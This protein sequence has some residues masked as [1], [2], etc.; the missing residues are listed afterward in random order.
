[1]KRGFGFLPIAA[2]S[3]L[4]DFASGYSVRFQ[5]ANPIIVAV[6]MRHV[7]AALTISI[8]ETTVNNI[9]KP[10]DIEKPKRA[11]EKYRRTFAKYDSF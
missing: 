6:A 10:T 2:K 11:P 4:E 1:M 8:D 3:S 7:I 5:A 9:S